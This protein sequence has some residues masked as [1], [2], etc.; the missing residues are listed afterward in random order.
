MCMSSTITIRLG[1]DDRRVLEDEARERG[2]GISTLMRDLAEAEAR[3]L[4]RVAIRAEGQR[5]IDYVARTAA[6]REELRELGTPQ[7]ESP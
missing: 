6:A 4:R 7:A 3:R 1:A 5:V 2:Q